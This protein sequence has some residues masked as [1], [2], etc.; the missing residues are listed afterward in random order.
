MATKI[1]SNDEVIVLAGKDR[2]KRGRVT[3]VLPT[4]KVIVENVNL[5]KKHQKPVPALGISAGI[6]EKEAALQASNVALFNAATG[7]ADRVGFR[8]ENDKK[9]RFFK[10][11]GETIK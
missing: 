2:G 4:G 5:V 10:S 11:S 9:V 8:F 1:R 6:V 3:Q 7:K